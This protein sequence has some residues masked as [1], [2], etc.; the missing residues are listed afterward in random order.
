MNLADLV[1]TARIEQNAFRGRRLAGID[2]CHNPDVTRIFQGELS[3]HTIVSFLN[4]SL[5]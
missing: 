1:G 4:I 5:R 3:W 2:M